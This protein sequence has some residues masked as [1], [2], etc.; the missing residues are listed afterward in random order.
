MRVANAAISYAAYLGQTFWPAGLA[1]LYPHPIA[2]GSSPENT[3]LI[4]KAIG[5]AAL[6]LAV[7]TAVLVVRRN[8]PW[9]VVGWLWYLGML[10][11]VIG[12]VQVGWQSMADR[13]TY[14]PQIGLLLGLTWTVVR[15]S[16]A[17]P[18]RRSA[19][20]LAA[21]LAIAGLMACA[22]RQTTFWRNSETL[23]SCA[24][25]CTSRNAVAHSGLG[26]VLQ[27]QGRIAEAVV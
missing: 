14:V 25:S 20:G 13:Y 21:V 24:L 2:T 16:S 3:V 6:L 9:L 10:F 4:W 26:V 19:C 15:L 8:H 17:W 11:P 18:F 27:K 22:W 12:L 23:W 7:T 1:V 5:A